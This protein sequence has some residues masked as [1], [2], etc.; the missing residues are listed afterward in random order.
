MEKGKS[1]LHAPLWVLVFVTLSGTLAM[2]MF[3]PALASAARDL[4]ATV[5]AIQ[6]TITMYILG[7]AVGQLAYGPISDVYGRRPTLLLGLLI[8]TIAGVVCLTA[9]SVHVLV[10][11]RFAQALGGCSGLLLGRAIVRDTS[12]TEDT[13]R[14]LSTL[15]L[16]SAAGPGL[17]PPNWGLDSHLAELALGF[18]RLYCT[19]SGRIATDLVCLAGNSPRPC[20]AKAQH[21][22]C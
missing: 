15:Q 10:I 18:C 5:A 8:F 16:M 12:T 20:N 19:R 17:A 7:L 4:H 13:M 3:V 21:S 6:S 14:R 9:Q 2:H 1:S 11:A 22:C